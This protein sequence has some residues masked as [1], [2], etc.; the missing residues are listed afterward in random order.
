[1][2]TAFSLGTSPSTFSPHKRLEEGRFLAPFPAQPFSA[3]RGQPS[4]KFHCT[5][6]RAEHTH[7]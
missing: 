6:T 5:Q 3:G 2:L 7:S 4:F 1:M